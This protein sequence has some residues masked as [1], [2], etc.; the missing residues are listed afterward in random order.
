MAHTHTLCIRWCRTRRGERKRRGRSKHTPTHLARAG[1]LWKGKGKEKSGGSTD[2]DQWRTSWWKTKTKTRTQFLTPKSRALFPCRDRV[3]KSCPNWHLTAIKF[4]R[5]RC[6]ICLSSPD[7]H[8]K[9]KTTPE[10]R[11]PAWYMWPEVM[12]CDCKSCCE[13]RG[14][15]LNRNAFRRDQWG[16]VDQRDFVK[17]CIPVRQA[18][19]LYLNELLD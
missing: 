8:Q 14:F 18:V 1:V 16:Q 3:V 11:V 10:S 5:I 12:Q 9:K 13:I 7:N 4:H 6:T 19:A 2:A 15:S 17:W